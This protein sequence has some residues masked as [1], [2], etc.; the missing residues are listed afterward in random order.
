MKVIKTTETI[1]VPKGVK[2]S[3]GTRSVHVT[4]Y[5][6]IRK[7]LAAVRTVCTHIENMIKG[8]TYGYR[9]KLNSLHAHFPINIIIGQNGSTVSIKNF[10]GEKNA[11]EVKMFPGIKAIS[12][13]TQDAMQIEGNDV[14]LVSK[15][16]A[17]IQQSC[18]ARHKDIRKF[19]DGVY[20]SH[21]GTVEEME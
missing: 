21:K 9:Y 1:K 14:E 18:Q 3:A 13:G 5:F 17:L 20:V 11:R 6:G 8:V 15:A 2:V 10:L 16:A 7:E 19:L 4:K 12:G